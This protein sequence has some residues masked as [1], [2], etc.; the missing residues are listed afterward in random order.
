MDLGLASLDPS[1]GCSKVHMMAVS[2][3]ED[4]ALPVLACGQHMRVA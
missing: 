1:N 2:T 4:K 3:C